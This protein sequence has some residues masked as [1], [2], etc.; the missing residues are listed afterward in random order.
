MAE[1]KKNGEIKAVVNDLKHANEFTDIENTAIVYVLRGW[2]ASLA[3]IPGA[4]EASDDVWALTTLYEHYT[5]ELNS[6]VTKRSK[7]ANKAQAIL[8]AKAKD[9]QDKL[10]T[11]LGADTAEDERINALTDAFTK[12]VIKQIG[13]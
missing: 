12:D 9:A 6:D 3:G 13:G 4:L 7:T 10:N 8:G 5:S 2:F 11:I 1:E